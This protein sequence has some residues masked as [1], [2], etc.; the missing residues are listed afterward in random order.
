[1]PNRSSGKSFIPQI[2]GRAL[3]T[4]K[5]LAAI[6]MVIDHMNFFWFGDEIFEMTLLGRAVFPLFCYAVVMAMLRSPGKTQ[7]YLYSLLLLGMVSEPFVQ[8]TRPDSPLNVIFTLALGVFVADISR[9]AKDWQLILGFTTCALATV[10][11]KIPLEFGLSGVALPAALM[12][13]TQGRMRLVP[14]LLLLLFTMNVGGVTE[15]MKN[16]PEL[17][18]LAPDVLY[19]MFAVG[20]SASL[21]PYILL[22]A[23]RDLPQKGRWLSRYSL[24]FFYP[25][26]QLLLWLLAL[27]F[28]PK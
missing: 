2:D 19:T 18:L 5:G 17:N 28:F 7:H 21:L 24:H 23:V 8:L 25:L 9:K 3:D 12:L 1:M 13:V 27:H 14:M 26:H 16:S 11:L 6:L 22:M 4:I 20:L 10:T 15:T